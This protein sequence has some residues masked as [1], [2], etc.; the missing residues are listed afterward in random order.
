MSGAAGTLATLPWVL[1]PLTTET[2]THAGE[3]G[4]KPPYLPY[5]C[6]TYGRVVS[7]GFAQGFYDATTLA[8]SLFWNV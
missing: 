1:P 4:V 5:L 8:L 6:D 2:G 3:N 7:V